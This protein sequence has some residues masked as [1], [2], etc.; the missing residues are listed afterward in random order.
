MYFDG[1]GNAVDIGNQN[2]GVTT[3]V[4]GYDLP[5]DAGTSYGVTLEY[6]QAMKNAIVQWGTAYAGDNKQV[7][8]IVHTDQHGRL[9]AS[10]KGLFDLLSYLVNW[11]EVSTIFNLG[12]TVVDHWEDD[13]TNANPLLRNA[14]LEAALLCLKDIPKDKQINVYG[15]HDT[16][17]EGEVSTAVSG[18]LPSMQYN[19]PYFISTGLR[20]EKYPDNSGFMMVYDDRLRVK[21]LVVASWDYADKTTGITGYQWYWIS[22]EHLQW[23]IDKMSEDTGHDLVIVSHVP[24]EMGGS[25]AIDPITSESITKS[26]PTYII[27]SSSLLNAL[28]NARKNRTTG[29]V[30][31]ISYD[32]TNCSDDLLCAIAG[33]THYDGVDYVDGSATGLLVTSFD[34]FANQTI[35]FGLIDRASQKIKGWKLSND[36][37]VPAVQNWEAPFD[38]Q[39]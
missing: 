20:T 6:A 4:L 23:V 17:Y 24:L 32:F 27:H 8:F 21:Y 25:L 16:W 12:D 36:N 37:N 9:N 22:N 28:W 10:N 29:T 14:T 33:H 26:S 13:N 1:N 31:G 15:N 2:K 19:N 30:S 7:P 38:Y 39:S 18:T 5:D 11:D 35:T 3:T 34:W